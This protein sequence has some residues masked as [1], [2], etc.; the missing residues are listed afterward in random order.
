MVVRRRCVCARRAVHVR[1]AVQG[2]RAV[3][4]RARLLGRRRDRRRHPDARPEGQARLV[5]VRRRPVPVLQRR[6]LHLQQPERIVPVARRRALPG[7]LPGADGRAARARP[8]PEPEARPGRRGRRADPH[9]RHRPALVGVPDRAEHPPGR[10]LVARQGRVDRLPA[11]RRAVARRRDPPCG[12]RR[13]ARAR[14]LPALLE[15][16]LPPRH[17]LGVQPRASQRHVQPQPA[18]LRPRLDLLLRPLGRRS[19]A[20]VDAHARGAGHRLAAASDLAPALAARRRVPDRSVDPL[21]PGTREPRRP[22]SDRRLRRP[23]PPRRDQDGRPGPTGGADRL[24]RAHPSRGRR[25]ARRRR[26]LRADLRGCDR[27]CAPA[28]G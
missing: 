18:D 17:R 27:R 22:G 5:A 13:Q 10:H 11:R 4:Q 19:P 3:D 8:A 26:G 16:R 15:H 7:R 20:P 21:R 2:L 9:D 1:A 12:R 28:P 25:R 23:L 6:R 14:L 24:A